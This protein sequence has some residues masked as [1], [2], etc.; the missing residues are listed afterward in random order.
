MRELLATALGDGLLDEVV[1]L[2]R[3]LIRVD[4]TNPPGNE[5][6]GVEVLEAYLERNG[7]SSE[8]V[9]RDPERANLI[10]RVRGRGTGPSLALAGHTD[11]VY[12]DA[13]DWSSPP[14][15]G[16]LRDGHLWGRG[17]LDM[18]GQ[19]A[20]SAVAL[21]V[22]ARSGWEPNGD[23]LLIAEA[24]EEDGVDDV[25]MSWLVT[26]RPD[27][28][29]DYA[30]TEANYR[31]P[32]AD[33]RT[34][35]T[36]CAGEKMTMPVRVRVRGAAGH[37]SVPT[38]GDNALLKL[39]PVLERLAAYSP[40][41]RSSP[42]LDALLDVLAPGNG[43]LDARIERGRA[44]HEELWHLLPAMAGSTFAP[45]M[46]GASRKRNVIPA[47][48]EIEVDCRVLPGTD[49]EELFGEFRAAL[50]GLDV[51]LE[52]AE[53]PVGGTRSELDTPLRD[54]LAEWIGE[55]E[56]GALLVPELS[57]GFTDAHYLREA[58][59]TI[60]YGFFPLRHTAPELLNTAH[61]PDERIDVRDLEL[62]VRAFVHCID[63]I[64]S[65]TR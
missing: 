65:V 6:R 38:L 26:E 15:G 51:E 63:R 34:V 11:V 32:L 55:L 36:L 12:A 60:A 7:V 42:E 1:E 14:F 31:L 48:A 40:V 29:C 33:G 2:T 50:H 8:R 18:K 22:L 17:A 28:R 44:Q 45:T 13:A 57:T 62:A 25:G 23:V 37:A 61:A 19:T 52:L 4:T 64:G 58:F 21:A 39:A 5:T 16:E 47:V 24:D 27:L 53:E 56:P 35:Y 3:D 41:R 59:G 43:S 54:A 20:A 46:A 10:A 9:A 49:P 30:I